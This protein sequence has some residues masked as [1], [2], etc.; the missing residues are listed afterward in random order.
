MGG[1]VLVL[2]YGS[3]LFCILVCAGKVVHVLRL[4]LHLK[5]EYYR[6]S[7]VYEQV[8]WWTQEPV[9]FGEK[10][11]KVLGQ[12]LFL[13]DYYERNRSFWYVLYLFHVGIYLLILWHAWLF[14]SAGFIDPERASEIG[15]VWGHV[16][17]G[18]AFIG[19]AGILIKRIADEEMKIYYQPIHYI[20]WAI[21]LLTLAGGF[22]AVYGYF[23]D[24]S[25]QL[26]RY[27]QSQ[28]TFSSLE[29]KLHPPPATA[30]HVLFG[31]F[32]LVYL[33]YSHI[34]RLFL[35]YYHYL[36]DDEVPNVKGGA[37]EK[38]IGQLLGQS[39]GWSAPHIQTGKTWAEVATTIPK[40]KAK[41]KK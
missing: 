7:S 5:W 24:S 3:I 32:W 30:V 36:H 39:V 29:H 1:I 27:V 12:V 8:D 19:G 40:D 17:T 4:P 35:R 33:P 15:I 23:G 34:M 37:M 6:E 22:Y 21:L 11:K 28:V 9:S 25:T 31:A 18:L 13:S 10:V 14:L 16:A 2:F 26:F 20:K 41:E 38:R